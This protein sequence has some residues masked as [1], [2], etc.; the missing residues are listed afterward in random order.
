MSETERK[1][2][3]EL[4]EV[5][6][7]DPGSQEFVELALLLSKNPELRPQAREICFK[8]LT[9]DPHNLR[10]RLVLAKL[11][12]L[13]QMSAFCLRELCELNKQVGQLPSLDRLLEE[14]GAKGA[15]VS[16]DEPSKHSKYETDQPQASSSAVSSTAVLAEV[17][18]EGEFIDILDDLEEK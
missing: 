18:L 12:Y 7:A 10:G 2:V 11:F 13:D 14:L 5:V 16:S 4:Q 17:D 6:T 8:G 9:I 15:G 3:R 1:R